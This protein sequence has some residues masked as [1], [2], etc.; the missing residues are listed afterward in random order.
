[1]I[2]VQKSLP[3][4]HIYSYTP[5]HLRNGYLHLPTPFT[6]SIFV[7]THAALGSTCYCLTLWP[8]TQQLKTN[9]SIHYHSA[10]TVSFKFQQ[11]IPCIPSN[12]HAFLYLE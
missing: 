10:R 9:N 4:T 3:P 1:M 7:Y 2:N 12:G 8:T 6:P 11:L 5:T